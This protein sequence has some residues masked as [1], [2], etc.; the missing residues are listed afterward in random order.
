MP[1]FDFDAEPYRTTDWELGPE[2]QTL[3]GY[4]AERSRLV[5]QLEQFPGSQHTDTRDEILADLVTLATCYPEL[6]NQANA[7]VKTLG[8]GLLQE[9]EEQAA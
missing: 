2:N 3:I 1:L 6:D 8:H 9:L 4:L 7:V 5:K